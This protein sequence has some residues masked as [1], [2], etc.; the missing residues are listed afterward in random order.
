MNIYNI[1]K[2]KNKVKKKSQ[3]VLWREEDNSHIGE[4]LPYL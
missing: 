2:F 3:L 1:R 4:A